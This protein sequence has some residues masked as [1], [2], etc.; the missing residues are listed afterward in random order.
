MQIIIFTLGDKY[1]ALKTENVEEI[2]KNMVVTKVPNSPTWVEGITN[3][4]GNVVTLINLS[5]LLQQ[6]D[7]MCYNNIIIVHNDE[8]MAGILVKDV[9][10]VVDIEEKDIQNMN[11]D[12][13]DGILGIV[14]INGEIINIIDINILL[15]K[16]EG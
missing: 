10:E 1:Y 11:H 8:E 16:N 12:P 13:L 14:R 7:D 4:R 6:E 15:S 9:M 5:K 3:L 2:S